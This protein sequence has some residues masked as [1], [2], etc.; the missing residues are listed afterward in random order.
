MILAPCFPELERKRWT[1]HDEHAYLDIIIFPPS[2]N[3]ISRQ[4]LQDKKEMTKKRKNNKKRESTKEGKY[5]LPPPVQAHEI[6]IF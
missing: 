2:R 1:G 6:A 5:R 3:T 4:I